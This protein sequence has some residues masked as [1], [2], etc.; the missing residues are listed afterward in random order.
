MYRPLQPTTF[1]IDLDGSR[2]ALVL[3]AVRGPNSFDIHGALAKASPLISI[4]SVSVLL[5]LFVLI[6]ASFGREVLKIVGLD[7]DARSET[8]I[9]STVVGV[10]LLLVLIFAS[11]FTGYIRAG[12]V[13]ILLA[14]FFVG[15]KN[16]RTVL[17]ARS[18]VRARDNTA[19]KAE[20]YLFWSVALTLTLEFLAA[21]APLT[22]SSVESRINGTVCELNSHGGSAI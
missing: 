4:L 10:A 18:I 20:K 8:L 12:I 5:S 7:L 19:S 6:A 21:M 9:C 3:L 17:D 13:V 11:Q 16:L 15:R 22:A 14:A 1:A 2:S